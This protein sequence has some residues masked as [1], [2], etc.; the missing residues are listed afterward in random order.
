VGVEEWESI[1]ESEIGAAADFFLFCCWGATLRGTET[2]LHSPQA[3]P[4]FL[5]PL[6]SKVQTPDVIVD[7]LIG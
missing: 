6:F 7:P 1:D 5:S 4:R 2:G 3:L